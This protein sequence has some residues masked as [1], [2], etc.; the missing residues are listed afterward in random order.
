MSLLS[1][2]IPTY[3][4]ESNIEPFCNAVVDQLNNF[5]PEYDYELIIIDN[6]SK[7]KTRSILQS[8]CQK[9]E[10]IK[11][12]FNTRN[13]NAFNSTV[14][15]LYQAKGD[16][17]IMMC[18]DFQDPVELIPQFVKEWE[19]GNKV[20]CGIKTKTKDKNKLLFYFRSLYYRLIRKMSD[21]NLIDHFTGFGLYDKSVL[22]ILRNI[23]DPLPSLRGMIAELGFKHKDI[24]FI[25]QPRRAGKSSFNFYRLYDAAMFNFTTY[26]K[27]GLRIAT[28]AGF[29]LSIIS[30]LIALVYF[31]L[32]LFHWDWFLAGMT[33]VLLGVFF[34]GS[35]QLFFIGLLGEYI[36]NINS[37][38]LNRPIIVEED[39][40]N[41]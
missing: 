8:L 15:G 6:D 27:I 13:F 9:D 31:V 16:C 25:Q 28:F 32:K 3:N 20:V 24:Y 2:V 39:R 11:A 38:L 40:I 17:A 29:I 14:Y 4:E 26:T 21:V 12:I 34:F 33:P 36:M 10:K 5:L 18:S 7:D 19:N 37:R 30:I 22:D 35:V 23:N 41:F 1:I